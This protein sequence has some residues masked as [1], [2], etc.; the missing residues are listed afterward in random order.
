MIHEKEEFVPLKQGYYSFWSI[1]CGICRLFVTTK[2]ERGLS[3][4]MSA[5]YNNSART[6]QSMLYG[7]QYGTQVSLN[8]MLVYIL[9]LIYI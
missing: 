8:Y 1:K 3:K 9:R 7:T 6:I 4:G 2:G 5:V